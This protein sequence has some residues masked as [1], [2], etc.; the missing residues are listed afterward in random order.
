MITKNAQQTQEKM[1]EHGEKFNKELDS[2]NRRTK[3]S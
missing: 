3:Q 1:D 2:T